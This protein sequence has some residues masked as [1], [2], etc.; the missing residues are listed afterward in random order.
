MPCNYL[1]KNIVTEGVYLDTS[2]SIL[3]DWYHG[4][5]TRFSSKDYV[6]FRTNVIFQYFM[7]QDKAEIICSLKTGDKIIIS[8]WVSLVRT[9]ARGLRWIQWLKFQANNT[10]P[11]ALSIN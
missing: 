9:N 7:K 6:N 10:L 1:K 5:D 3:D 8:G 11:L 2:T 4:R